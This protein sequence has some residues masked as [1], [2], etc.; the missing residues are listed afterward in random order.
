MARGWRTVGAGT[1]AT[2][3]LLLLL[4]P[5]LG[6][7]SSERRRAAAPSQLLFAPQVAPERRAAAPSQLLFA[8]AAAVRTT[9]DPAVEPCPCAS[10]ALCQPVRRAEPSEKVYVMHDGFV[11]PHPG[12][13]DDSYIWARYDWSKITTL[14]VFGATTFNIFSPMSLFSADFPPELTIECR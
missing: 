13:P 8:A 14:A 9:W 11:A 5:S 3:L 4:V 10:A 12:A 2:L 1:R 7:G 6:T